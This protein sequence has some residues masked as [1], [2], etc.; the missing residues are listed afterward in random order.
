MRK[1]LSNPLYVESAFLVLL[2]LLFAAATVYLFLRNRFAFREKLGA[3]YFRLSVCS[4]V[5]A[6]VFTTLAFRKYAA[7]NMGMLDLGGIDQAIWNTLHGSLLHVTSV[8]WGNISRLGAH[9]EPI[10]ILISP[11]YLLWDDA[12][13][14][15]IVQT[16]FIVAGAYPLFLIAKERLRNE[17]AAFCAALCCF[18]YPAVQWANISDFHGDPLAIPFLLFALYFLEKKK[19]H[20]SA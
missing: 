2:I 11:V 3:P 18:L 10:F 17:G 20:L 13:V 8:D 4:I 16:L 14:L 12:R 1:F 7:Y 6:A 5:Y 9:F 15:L 19:E